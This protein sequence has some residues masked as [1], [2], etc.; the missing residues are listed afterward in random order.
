MRNIGPLVAVAVFGAAC[1]NAEPAP[2]PGAGPAIQTYGVLR[3][4]EPDSLYLTRPSGIARGRHGET[5]VSDVV[6]NRVVTYDDSGRP[7]QAFGRP[8][9]GPG[10]FRQASTMF[11]RDDSTLAVADLSRGIFQLFNLRTGDFRASLSCE[12]IGSS[13]SYQDSV[14]WLGAMS[15]GRKT[16]V[17][18]LRA[19]ADSF[20]YLIPLPPEY[21]RMPWLAGTFPGARVAAWRDTLLVGMTASDVLRLFTADGRLVDSVVVPVRVRR[22]VPPDIERQFERHHRTQRDWVR[23]TSALLGLFR[24]SDGA[25]VLVHGDY[26]I[27]GPLTTADLFV[28]TLAPDRQHACVDTRLLVSHDAAPLVTFRADTLYVLDRQVVSDTALETR[29]TAYGVDGSRCHPVTLHEHR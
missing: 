17:A 18:A 7:V 14:I 19:S 11:F 8:G 25:F 26:D 1:T 13:V 2:P 12:G 6:G 4:V 27:V 5:Y 28:T 23:L 20:E 9:G 21:L 22:G 3:L 29:I 10:E 15:L 24:Q 16:S